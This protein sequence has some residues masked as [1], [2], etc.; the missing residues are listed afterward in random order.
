MSV[1]LSPIAGLALLTQGGVIINAAPPQEGYTLLFSSP[2]VERPKNPITVKCGPDGQFDLA[3]IEP[4]NYQ[5]RIEVGRRKA[6]II[7]E[8]MLDDEAGRLVLYWPPE[9]DT[10]KRKLAHSDLFSQG[11]NALDGGNFEEAVRLFGEAVRYDTANSP[12]WAAMALAQVGLKKHSEA[13]ESMWMAIRF[14]PRSDSYW[15]NL[16]GV[17][18]RMGKYREA[19]TMYTHA[20]DLNPEGVAIYMSNA[21]AAY[22]F[23]GDDDSAAESYKVA[24]TGQ[25][26]PAGTWFHYA[27]CLYRLRRMPD[28]K[29]AYLKYL[30]L[31]PN[32]VFIGNARRRLA[33]IG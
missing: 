25:G 5:L 15:N 9:M 18:Y 22:V 16:G 21:A 29:S 14:A 33:A 10:D 3:G 13:V 6:L 24:V 12:T 26:V 8:I 31:E 1:L 2:G 32:G 11:R 20:Y 19:A 30:E 7:P 23:A 28:A 17:L 27:E 4:G